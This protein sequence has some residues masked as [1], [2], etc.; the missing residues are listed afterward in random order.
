MKSQTPSRTY[1]CTRTSS[2]SSITGGQRKKHYADLEMLYDLNGE[3]SVQTLHTVTGKAGRKDSGG[4]GYSGSAGAPII[5]PRSQFNNL[6][7]INIDDDS[8]E[9]SGLPN[10]TKSDLIDL[11][12]ASTA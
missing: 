4:K 10:L 12:C 3:K 11:I 1:H 6:E 9:M 8:D 7:V 2:R 5:D